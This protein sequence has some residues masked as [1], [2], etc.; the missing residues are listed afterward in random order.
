M[1]KKFK[2]ERTFNMEAPQRNTIASLLGYCRKAAWHLAE[3]AS[4]QDS[5]PWAF[6]VLHPTAVWFKIQSAIR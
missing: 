3:I 6:Q 4:R 1:V 2:L 5:T